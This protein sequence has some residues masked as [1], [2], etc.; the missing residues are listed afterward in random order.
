MVEIGGYPILWHIL[1]IYSAHG[2]NDFVLALGYK[3]EIIK[4]Y[5][6]NYSYR[7]SDLVVDLKNDRVERTKPIKEDW[8]V[9]MFD[10]GSETMTGGRLLRLEPH[11][12]P[13]G[14]FMLTYGDGVANIDIKALLAFHQANSRL[15]TITAVRPTA[16]F[17]TMVFE[18]DRVIEFKEKPQTG[19]G[20]INGG[21]FVFE[22]GVFDYLSGDETVLEGEPMERL[23]ADGELMAYRH[24]GFWQPM[25]TLR[26]KQN[27]E[28][29]CAGGHAPWKLRD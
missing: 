5:F 13:K 17:G 12:R 26:D 25:D 18:R 21:F 10:T 27:L 28:T 2:F 15:A 7:C 6:L 29:M 3:G 4:D 23:A 8:L 20:W 1:K 22:P 11:L 24:N 9:H 16:R 14:T 19:E